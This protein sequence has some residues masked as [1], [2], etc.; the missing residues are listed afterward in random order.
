MNQFCKACNVKVDGKN[1]LKVRTLCKNCYYKKKIENTNN[2]I[3]IQ[4]KQAKTDKVKN[5]NNVRTLL[6]VLTF[7]VKHMLC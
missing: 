2:I 7:R 6:V 1:D 3:S 4:N 5:N